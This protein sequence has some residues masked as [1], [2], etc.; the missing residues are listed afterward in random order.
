MS[1]VTRLPFGR[2]EPAFETGSYQPPPVPQELD[3]RRLLGGLR[4]RKVLIGGI[5]FLLTSLAVLFVNQITPRYFAEALLVVEGNRQNVVNI[6]SVAQGINPDYYT[7]ETQAAIVASRGLAAQAVDRLDL[8]HSPLFNPDLA[9]PEASLIDVIRQAVESLTAGKSDKDDAEPLSP[10]DGMTAAE[11]RAAMKDYMTALYLSGL[12]VQPSS[13]SRVLAVQYVSTDPEFAARAANTTAELYIKDQLASKGEVTSKASE[14]LDKRV[15]ELGKRMVESERRLEE[16]RRESGI[17]EV[18]GAN[19]LQEQLAKL[20][21]EL[22]TA[23]TRRAEAEARHA[24]VVALLN[25]GGGVETAAAV[26]DAPLIVRL[27]EQE[28][29]V[30]RKLGELRTELRDNHPRMI[31]VKRELEDLREKISAEVGKI[32][33]NLDNERQIARV[34]ERNLEREVAKLEAQLRDQNDSEVQLRSLMS[35]VRANKQLYETVLA[36]FKETKVFDKDAQQ[37]DARVISRA[38]VPGKPFYPQKRLMIIAAFLVSTVLAVALALVLEYLDSG[39]RSVTQLESLT[40]IPALGAVPRLAKADRRYK[41][42]E[43][44]L[45]KPNSS[46]GESIRSLRTALML[47]NVE[48]PPKTVLF[49]SALAGEGKSTLSLSLATMAARSG[50]RCIILD[51]DLRHPNIHTLLGHPNEAGIGDYLAGRAAL[52]DVVEID[53]AS[54]VH[55]IVAGA[56]APNPADMLGSPQMRQLLA[57]LA[58]LYDLVVVDSPPLLAVSDSLVMV[59]HVDRTVFVVRWEKTRRE[60]AHAGIKQLVDAGARLAGLVLA[61][62]DV[63]KQARYGYQDSGYYY[64]HTKHDKYYVE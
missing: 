56:R 51:C 54:G 41:P 9:P 36:R 13:R 49:T 37:A 46:Y 19:L 44:A 58:G 62:V 55:F 15:A 22:V 2:G 23:R 60:T 47:S 17:V 25:G 57:N 8:Y 38:T 10:W 20:N 43:F 24:Q 45:K 40:G 11:K 29:V 28:A 64:R 18:G 39:F 59:R 26:L 42:H 12:T 52:D 14:W 32:A 63:R 34:R 3:P 7:N 5:I 1:T 33:V 6:E 35:E 48:Q 61:Q 53:P 27:R 4:R 30:L 31:L 16:F 50:Q 21:G